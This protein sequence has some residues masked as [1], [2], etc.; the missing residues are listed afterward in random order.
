MLWVAAELG[1]PLPRRYLQV[2][3]VD[4]V[5]Y[6]LHVAVASEELASQTE[7][8]EAA[9]QVAEGVLGQG[10]H[11][12]PVKGQQGQLTDPVEGMDRQHLDHV[13]AEV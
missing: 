10:G 2:K 5:G 12:V 4:P 8:A 1:V 7:A 13:E 6:P 3:V 11:R 9:V